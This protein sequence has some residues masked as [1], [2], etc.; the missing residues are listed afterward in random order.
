MKV[1]QAQPQDVEGWFALRRALWPD[2]PDQDHREEIQAQFGAVDLAG[3]VAEAED[4]QLVGFLEASLRRYAEGCVG[5]PVGY[6]E[7]WYVLPAWR[8][9]GV[10]AMLVEAAERWAAEQGCAEMASDI[11]LDNAASLKAHMALGFV[12]AER[13]IRVAKKIRKLPEARP[14]TWRV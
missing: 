1:R 12:E 9:Q 11:E 13:L 8:R 4:G 7:G 2:C 6:I 3:F 10:G 14:R 5:S